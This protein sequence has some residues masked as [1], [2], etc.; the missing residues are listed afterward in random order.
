MESATKKKA[1]NEVIKT[2][3]IEE[4]FLSVIKYSLKQDVA[5]N[6]LLKNVSTSVTQDMSKQEEDI[7]SHWA[8]FE[9]LKKH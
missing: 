4:E 8:K 1:R 2:H 5:N 3:Y 9:D 6:V 7:A